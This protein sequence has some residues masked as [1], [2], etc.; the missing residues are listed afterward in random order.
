MCYGAVAASIHGALD[1]NLDLPVCDTDEPA[2]GLQRI[3]ARPGER[4]ALGDDEQ[5]GDA[6]HVA[7]RISE[8]DCDHAAF[9]AS[10]GYIATIAMYRGPR[11]Q[12]PI[13]GIE[14][15]ALAVLRPEWSIAPQARS[16]LAEIPEAGL[17]SAML[18]ARYKWRVGDT[19]ILHP[20]FPLVGDLSI[21]VAGVVHDSAMGLV[22]V[23]LD[24][25]DKLMLKPRNVI[26][27]LIRGGPLDECITGGTHD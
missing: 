13:M 9:E 2:L 15:N 19:I 23:P 1:R 27:Y 16:A 14:P 12:I 7:Q 26:A 4:I 17:V 25:L 10:S 3:A 20:T 5:R 22:I 21:R 18:A 24:R 8:L 11:E 6:L